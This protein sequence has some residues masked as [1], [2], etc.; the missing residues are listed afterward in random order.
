MTKIYRIIAILFSLLLL[1]ATGVYLLQEMRRYSIVLT[2]VKP[3]TK[4]EITHRDGTTTE[5][6]NNTP[7]L[8]KKG[9]YTVRVTSQNGEL[10]EKNIPIT[11]TNDMTVPID[12]SYSASYRSNILQSHRKS[13]DSAIEK[14]Y[15]ELSRYYILRKSAL[16]SNRLDW[17]IANYTHKDGRLGDND[18]Y[19]IILKKEGDE[20][21]IASRPQIVHTIFNTKDIPKDILSE[22]YR[23]SSIFSAA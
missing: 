5:V 21:K 7:L 15:P 13:I 19:T 8:L 1:V 18:T 9:E 14:T 3:F 17:H 6:K 22:I 4:L 11:V 10:D 23:E 20:W 2:A 16:L 12:T